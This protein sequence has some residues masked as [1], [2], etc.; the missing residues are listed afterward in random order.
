MDLTTLRH[1]TARLIAPLDCSL[2]AAVNR[3]GNIFGTLFTALLLSLASTATLALPGDKDDTFGTF[4]GSGN[5]VFPSVADNFVSVY[6]GAV[7]PDDRIVT[8]GVC[9]ATVGSSTPAGKR[10]CIVVWSVDGSS[11]T[12]Y[13]HSSANNRIDNSASG[14]LAVQ[15]DGKI[16]VAAQCIA[17]VGETIIRQCAARFNANFTSDTSFATATENIAS[18]ADVS[19]GQNSYANDVAIQPDGKI[20]LAGQ[21]GTSLGTAMCASRFLADGTRDLSV[22]SASSSPGITALVPVVLGGGFDRV[23]RIAVAASGQIYLAGTC[24]K[25]FPASGG[26]AAATLTVACLARLNADGSIDDGFARVTPATPTS[27][28]PYALKPI[29]GPVLDEDVTDLVI[30]ANGEIVIASSCAPHST[31]SFVPCLRRFAAPG[32]SGQPLLPGQLYADA[33]FPAGNP[34]TSANSGL[35]QDSGALLYT[36]PFPE[37]AVR[38]YRVKLLPDSRL[39]ML[40]K[41]PDDVEHRIRLY[42]TNGVIDRAWNEVLANQFGFSNNTVI[43]TTNAR[44]VALDVQRNGRVIAMGNEFPNSL[45]RAPRVVAFKL[46]NI[47]TARACNL[48]IDN[49]GKILPTTDGLLLS[50]AAAGLT[51]NAVITGAIGVGALRNDWPKIRDY[52]NTQCGMMIAP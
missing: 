28:T 1:A 2:R 11:S 4:N 37:G 24:K 19:F 27:F 44:A 33:A 50:R 23:K 35:G 21:C 48:D 45:V 25:T 30:Q 18:P 5:G 17:A 36:A 49:D 51:G 9:E 12:T 20:I 10:F 31:G 7:L 41:G 42:Y 43:N 39:L 52:L 47:I 46:G 15:R 13:L 14:G 6:G 16:V 29:S 32:P 8:G 3:K 40:I 34:F 38:L 26:S 22:S